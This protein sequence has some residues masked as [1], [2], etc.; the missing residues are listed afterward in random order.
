MDHF[1]PK[2]KT[3][4]RIVAN[5]YIEKDGKRYLKQELACKNPNCSNDGK[6]LVTIEEEDK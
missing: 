2:C 4:L 5:S 6:I 3:L 1:C